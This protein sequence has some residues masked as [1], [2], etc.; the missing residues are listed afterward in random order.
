MQ[1]AG[2]GLSFP[3]FPDLCLHFPWQHP[4]GQQAPTWPALVVHPGGLVPGG[5]HQWCGSLLYHALRP[6][7]REG[8]LPPLAPVHG[9]LLRG[10]RVRHTALEGQPLH[11][12]WLH[13]SPCL[14]SPSSGFR[15]PLFTQQTLRKHPLDAGPR[16][17]GRMREITQ[18]V[19]AIGCSLWARLCAVRCLCL[20]VTLI[21]VWVL[22]F[23]FTSEKAEVKMFKSQTSTGTPKGF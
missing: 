19:L 6:A 2:L 1:V 8:H 12:T 9:G 22:A 14:P 17:G 7:L 13:P 4:A 21:P 3:L 10:E 15:F 23:H 20:L 16:A 11:P 5:S 18:T